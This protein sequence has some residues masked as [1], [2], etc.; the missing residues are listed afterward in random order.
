MPRIS[1]WRLKHEYSHSNF[2]TLA[3]SVSPSVSSARAWYDKVAE[4]T[5]DAVREA[6]AYCTA[7]QTAPLAIAIDAT[8]VSKTRSTCLCK[9]NFM[10]RAGRSFDM[11]SC[12]APPAAPVA[13]TACETQPLNSALPYIQVVGVK[14]GKIHGLR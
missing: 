3:F 10:R 2:F 12:N 1:K 11:Q 14:F 5:G 9:F 8:E 7:M 4:Q 6:T 13:V